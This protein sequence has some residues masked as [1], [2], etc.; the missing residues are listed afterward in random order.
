M[1]KHIEVPTNLQAVEFILKELDIL[2][3]YGFYALRSRQY[4]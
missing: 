4:F 3:D 1:N 2:Y